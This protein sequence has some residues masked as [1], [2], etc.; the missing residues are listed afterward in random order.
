MKKIFLLAYFV[1]IG[2]ISIGN[3]LLGQV[4]AFD[5]SEINYLSDEYTLSLDQFEEIWVEEDPEAC[6]NY[7]AHCESYWDREYDESVVVRQDGVADLE[8]N[9]QT[10]FT[11]SGPRPEQVDCS[12]ALYDG[13]MFSIATDGS[14]QLASS[15]SWGGFSPQEGVYE[16]DLY[17]DCLFQVRDDSFS[18][19]LFAWLQPKVAYAASSGDYFGTIRFTVVDKNKPAPAPLTL[20]EKA[21]EL[22]KEVI[23]AAY[24]GDGKTY[25]GKGWDKNRKVYVDTASIFNG[26]DYWNNKTGTT[27][28]GAGLDCSGLIEWAY[29]YSFDPEKSLTKNVIRVEGANKQYLENS[30]PILE[31]ELAKGDLLFLDKNNKRFRDHVAVYVG[32]FVNEGEHFDIVEAFSQERGI[33]V[34]KFA[35]YRLR[36][37]FTNIVNYGSNPIRRVVISPSIAGQVKVGS[38]VDITVTDPEGITITP[39]TFIETDEEYLTEV[40]GEL[41][42]SEREFGEDGRPRDTVYWFKNKVGNYRIQVIPEENTLPTDTY[43]LEFTIG[44][45]TTKLAENVPISEI[46]VGG[47]YVEVNESEEV[48]SSGEIT[49]D[50]LL[51]KIRSYIQS[52]DVSDRSKKPLFA[53]VDAIEKRLEINQKLQ[54]KLPKHTE[55]LKENEEAILL[56]LSLAENTFAEKEGQKLNTKE[57]VELTKALIKTLTAFQK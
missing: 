3:V 48:G 26:Y 18:D 36:L 41:Y 2:W 55:K 43:S 32:D 5:L 49:S 39:D 33:A 14:R 45:N 28:S 13:E 4:Y 44:E 6:E 54:E 20:P 1:I 25:G 46:P 9:K 27:T 10:A 12:W 38:P 11:F 31:D 57:V 50:Y 17:I 23:G 35:D 40:P 37:G 52:F 30:N 42:Y 51:E 56:E 22:A 29:N 34:A 24:L 47:Y 21:A 19:R 15:G 7:G 16:A 53:L 8:L